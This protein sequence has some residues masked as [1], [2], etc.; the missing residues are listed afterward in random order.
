MSERKT[1]STAPGTRLVINSGLVWNGKR[2]DQM[3]IGF[4]GLGNVGAKLAG[5]LLRHEFELAIRDIDKA[6]AADLL[7]KGAKWADSGRALA[8]ASDVM[9]QDG[10]VIGQL[11]VSRDRGPIDPQWQLQHQP[12]D[13]S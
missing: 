11:V 4:I 1:A 3:K 8:E 12:H 5:S 2:E 13:G 6:A 7:E 10:G 9:E